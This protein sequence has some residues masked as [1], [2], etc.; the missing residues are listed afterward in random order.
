M[1]KR[2]RIRQRGRKKAMKSGFP[3]HGRS[4][5]A[6]TSARRADIRRSKELGVW[7]EL[8]IWQNPMNLLRSNVK[9]MFGKGKR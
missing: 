7:Q 5:N 8:G 1:K 3:I 6:G 2:S 4:I 9:R